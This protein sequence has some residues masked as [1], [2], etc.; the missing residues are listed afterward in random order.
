MRASHG[1]SSYS[2]VVRHLY[3]MTSD[4]LLSTLGASAASHCITTVC[5]WSYDM[6]AMVMMSVHVGSYGSGKLR[7]CISAS[8]IITNYLNIQATGA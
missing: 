1:A 8:V 5:V 3:S 6:V 2:L 7:N 4:S